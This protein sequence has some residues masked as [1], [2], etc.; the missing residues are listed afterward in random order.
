MTR[1]PRPAE[2]ALLVLDGATALAHTERIIDAYARVYGDPPFNEGEADVADFRA[3][4]P[5]RASVPGFRLVVAEIGG[6][7][8]GF[9]FGHE[10]AENT[11]WWQGVIGEPLD[12]AFTSERPGRTFAVIE[13]A[14]LQ[15]YRGRGIGR[16][17]HDTLL[18]GLPHERVTLL[19][20]TDTPVAHGL[21][22]RS[23]YPMALR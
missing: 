9:A 18:A 7:L 6:R 11:R 2:V 22:D 12:S 23:G 10:L 8:C 19:V 13:L 16:M 20:R 21:Y 3:S 1:K 17:L 5:R 4:W 15:E 14:V